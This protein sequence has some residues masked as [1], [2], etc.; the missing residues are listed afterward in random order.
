MY[1]CQTLKNGLTIIGEEIPYLKSISLGV[2]VKAGSIMETK[3]NSG[4]SHFIE[5]MLFK[6]TTN[7][8]SKELAREID[9]LGGVIN[10]FTSKECTCFY[11]KLLD[12]HINIGIDVLSDMILNSRFDELDIKKEKSVILEELKMYEDSPDDLVY[13][14]LLENIYKDHSLGMNILG[15]RQ[16]LKNL[17]RES[18]LDYY[19]E[20]YVP[21]N[22]I[23]SICG[24]FKFEE[25]VKQIEEKFKTWQ[26][27]SVDTTT[28][29][30]NFNP[31]IVKKNKD[32][33]QVNLAINL[34][35]I[36]M[37]NNR[38][39]YALSVVNNVFGGSIS[40]RLFQKIREE[41]GLAYS[42]YSSQT[43]YEDCG[44]LG[45]FAST[46][47]ENIQEVYKSILE[48]IELIRNE[49]ISPQEIHE[50]KEQ[51]KGSYMLDLEST[52]SRMMSNGKNLL[53]RNKVDD[54]QDIIDY[55]NAVEYD[56][57]VKI[58]K[59]VFN[60]E[61]MGVCIVGKDVEN[62]NL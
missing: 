51:L 6:G 41:K 20:Y 36:P 40:S 43:L 54:E 58:I 25:I 31:C 60:T 2:W 23:I 53:M 1:K 4:V 30:P 62:I 3:E 27:K 42:I 59:K 17:K 9:N 21:N 29:K 50:S 46:S 35:A 14:L 32:I 38:E 44:E 11:V 5:H 28:T 55:I 39:V 61:N 52:S 49:Y 8:T 45:I 37:T 22:S 57:V 18:I 56:D 34:D 10:A 12:E 13:D 26:P 33:E 47:T 24:N 19:N 15:D 16:S 48:E 7:R